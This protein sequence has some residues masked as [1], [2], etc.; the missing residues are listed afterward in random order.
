MTLLKQIIEPERLLVVWQCLQDGHCRGK[1]YI[2]GE[3]RYLDNK[4]I[5][6]SYFSET[7]DFQKAK[8]FGFKGFS[9]F[10]I[11]TSCH[12]QN[13]METL[14]RRI[15]S[16]Q[17]GDFNDFLQYYRITPEA[18]KEMSDFALLGYTG[19]NLPGDNFTF[20]HTFENA[21]LPCELIIEVA[22]I[23]H[24][25]QDLENLENLENLSVYFEAEPN[26]IQDSNAVVIKTKDNRKLIGY[27]NRA[28]TEIFNKWISNKNKVE[29][30]IERINGTISRPS[31]LLYLTVS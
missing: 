9:I 28:Q 8:G 10:G 31:L 6:L 4:E 11:D 30:H 24:Y 27:V 26:N 25:M 21:S 22:G 1:R 13:V 17:R 2:V 14:R 15:L 3:L 19:G 5:K 20:I 7:E 16:R 18:G 29:A 23:S 12:T